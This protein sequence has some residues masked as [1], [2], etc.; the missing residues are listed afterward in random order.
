MAECFAKF[1]R[2]SDQRF[3]YGVGS[4]SRST[5]AAVNSDEFLFAF[6]RVGANDDDKTAA[7]L[8]A[9]AA[10]FI[11]NATFIAPGSMTCESSSSG[12]D[13]C[14][15]AFDIAVQGGGSLETLL[16]LFADVKVRA[17]VR[18]IC[19]HAL[20]DGSGRVKFVG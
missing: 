14:A 8:C 6:S 13:D 19:T 4:D 20:V 1:Q 18:I 2:V 17:T 5:L 11:P 16:L 12:G 7:S 15:A 3:C 10:K 9:E